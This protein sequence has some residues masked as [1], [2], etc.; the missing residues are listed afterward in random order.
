MAKKAFKFANK[1]HVVAFSHNEPRARHD[2][3]VLNRWLDDQEHYRVM[4]DNGQIAEFLV[5]NLIA[6]NSRG[7]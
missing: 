6:R 7:S 3:I 4:F 1:S 5:D 2:A